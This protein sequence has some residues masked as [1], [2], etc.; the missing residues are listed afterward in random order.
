MKISIGADHRGFELK[1]T[2]IAT[3]SDKIEWID[4]GAFDNAPSDYPA[5]ATAVCKQIFSGNVD[6]GVLICA[7]GVGMSIV[8]NRHKGIFA[9]LCWCKKVAAAAK[10]DDNAN[11]L[12]LPADFV[13]FGQA[14]EIIYS[15]LEAQF[16]G[17]KYKE[18]I[19]SI[20]E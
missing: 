16:K 3:F 2:L 6:V 5:F 11:V 13:S 19:E 18:R 15:W 20:D 14:K 4:C 10:Q 9:A 8:A 7:S 1:Q 17:G 12:V